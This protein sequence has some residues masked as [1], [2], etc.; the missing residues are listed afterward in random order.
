MFDGLECV[1]R[2]VTRYALV[3][4]MYLKGRSVLEE[5][6]CNALTRVYTSILVFLAHTKRYLVRCNSG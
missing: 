5:Q 1:S 6:L 2:L 3:E 4:T